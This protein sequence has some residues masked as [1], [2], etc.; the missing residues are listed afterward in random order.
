M[1]VTIWASDKLTEF[2][3]NNLNWTD[4]EVWGALI[5]VCKEKGREYTEDVVNLKKQ[6]VKNKF[7]LQVIKKLG[8]NGSF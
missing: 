1:T 2:L 5:E 7:R 8:S 3:K 6:K 4:E